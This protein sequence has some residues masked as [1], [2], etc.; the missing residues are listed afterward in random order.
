LT[1]TIARDDR[2]KLT[3]SWSIKTQAPYPKVFCCAFFCKQNS[4]V[5]I[6]YYQAE[7]P[8]NTQRA[9]RRLNLSWKRPNV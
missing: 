1:Q 6:I 7:I 4:D 3:I 5:K 8:E 9:R 2:C